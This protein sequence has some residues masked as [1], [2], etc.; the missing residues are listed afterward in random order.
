MLERGNDTAHDYRTIA[1]PGS[2][3]DG[4]STKVFPHTVAIGNIQS[5]IMAGKLKGAMP[6]T[7][8]NG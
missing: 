7:T 5:G 3:S 1:A 8:P 2:R 6:A 4:F